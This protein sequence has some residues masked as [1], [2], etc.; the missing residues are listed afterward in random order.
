MT[1]PLIEYRQGISAAA[2]E[3][4]REMIVECSMSLKEI[5]EVFEEQ[6]KR[7]KLPSGELKNKRLQEMKQ[8]VF[9]EAGNE[10]IRQIKDT[11]EEFL[12]TVED[13]FDVA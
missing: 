2:N 3:L 10:I 13:A 5:M 7:I 12:E 4:E 9:I 6:N 11:V 8:K 1:L